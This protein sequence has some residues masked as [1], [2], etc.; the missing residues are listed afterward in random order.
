[1]FTTFVDVEG[2]AVACTPGICL[3]AFDVDVVWQG[4]FSAGLVVGF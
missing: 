4:E 1:V 3:G 2:R